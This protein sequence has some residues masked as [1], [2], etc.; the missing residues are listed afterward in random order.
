MFLKQCQTVIRKFKVMI[1]MIRINKYKKLTT[2]ICGKFFVMQNLI[3]QYHSS[4]SFLEQHYILRHNHFLVK[5]YK[6]H[7]FEHRN[8]K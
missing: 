8:D 7:H 2:G 3:Q 6:L 5:W 1:R 4:V